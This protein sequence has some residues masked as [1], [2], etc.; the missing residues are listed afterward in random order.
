MGTWE[1][2][3]GEEADCCC[4]GGAARLSSRGGLEGAWLETA[5]REAE[6][7]DR[8]AEMPDRAYIADLVVEMP[9]LELEMPDPD[10]FEAGAEGS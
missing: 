10:M 5:D 9:D 4:C 7:P 6:M 3:Q 1:P 8:E 2:V